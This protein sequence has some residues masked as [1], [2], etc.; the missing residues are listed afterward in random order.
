MWADSDVDSEQ[1]TKLPDGSMVAIWQSNQNDLS[2]IVS[3]TCTN[4]SWATPVTISDSQENSS[5]PKLY[6]DDQGNITVGW[7]ALDSTHHAYVLKVITKLV[8]AS[9]GAAAIVSPVGEN[10]QTFHLKTDSSI[11]GSLL[12]IWR[13]VN[14]VSGNNGIWVSTAL[15]AAWSDPT[16]ISTEV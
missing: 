6:I 15:G 11:V 10:V 3:S 4:G 1:I 13:S 8:G 7:L 2:S 9:W 5:S 16:K 12:A 14:A